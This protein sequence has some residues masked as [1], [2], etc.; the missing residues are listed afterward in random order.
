MGI[1]SDGPS[2]MDL[3]TDG[4]SETPLPATIVSSGNVA[5]SAVTGSTS[6]HQLLGSA[7]KWSKDKEERGAQ[8]AW[9]PERPTEAWPLLMAKVGHS[10]IIGTSGPCT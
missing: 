1:S 3:H 5:L 9:I 7:D 4:L 6:A 2:E 8:A 10:Q